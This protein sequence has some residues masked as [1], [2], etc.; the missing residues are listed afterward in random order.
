MKK[1][2]QLSKKNSHRNYSVSKLK[3]PFPPLKMLI[4]RQRQ[5]ITH[6]PFLAPSPDLKVA[7]KYCQRLVNTHNNVLLLDEWTFSALFEPELCYVKEW[8][9]FSCYTTECHPPVKGAFE[10]IF[11]T[12]QHQCIFS[13]VLTI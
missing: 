8:L 7:N 12:R 5:P 10:Q 13:P 6:V 1:Y 9:C 11:S 2:L 3:K 4:V